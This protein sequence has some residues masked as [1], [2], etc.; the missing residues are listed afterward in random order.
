MACVARVPRRARA[1][2]SPH[3]I[4]EHSTITILRL[5]ATYATVGTIDKRSHSINSAGSACV[6]CTPSECV[7]RHAIDS[8]RGDRV[9]ENPDRLIA[10]VSPRSLP[11][12]DLA[13]STSARVDFVLDQ[14]IWSGCGKRYI[15]SRGACVSARA[16][17]LKTMPLRRGRCPPLA[18]NLPNKL[19]W[20]A[21]RQDTAVALFCTTDLC[22]SRTSACTSTG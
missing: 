11:F 4:W 2:R 21:S 7:Q 22:A 8:W 3:T 13:N 15:W 14:S 5:G 1:N 17:L 9:P 12:V 20:R 19:W 6:T 16:I 18:Q 10:R